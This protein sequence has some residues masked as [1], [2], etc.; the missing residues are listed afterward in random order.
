MAEM[1]GNRQSDLPSIAT[2]PKQHFVRFPVVRQIGFY[3]HTQDALV[4]YIIGISPA[5]FEIGHCVPLS[6]MTHLCIFLLNAEK[7]ILLP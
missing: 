7:L 4:A 1:C 2:S 6:K 5:V 3:I